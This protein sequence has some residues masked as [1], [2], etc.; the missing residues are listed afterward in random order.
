MNETIKT[1]LSRR[2][3]RDYQDKSIEQEK[4]EQI[5]TAGKAAPSSRNQQKYL[6]KVITNVDLI[7]ELAQES[8][9]LLNEKRPEI[10]L[11]EMAD[12]IFYQAPLL[13]LIFVEKGDKWAGINAG[14]LASNMFNAAWSL[15]I[16]SCYIGLANILNQSNLLK[17]KIDYP[18]DYELMT[19]L[20][21]GYPKS[22]QV[23]VP[24]RKS[25]NVEYV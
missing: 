24:V 17:S 7:Q 14:L 11:R 16:G 1:L 2:S 20:I 12:P 5:I 6:I 3:H 23:P 22:D 10:S 8:K 25:D 15:G 19:P 4:I 21:F 9:R 18:D 13:I